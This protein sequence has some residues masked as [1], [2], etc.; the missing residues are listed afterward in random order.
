M[1]LFKNKIY[2]NFTF[3]QRNL[4]GL[5]YLLDHDFISPSIGNISLPVNAD[6]IYKYQNLL[7]LL[8]SFLLERW[9][10]TFLLFL[11]FDAESFFKMFW[12]Y[13]RYF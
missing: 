9:G 12:L 7:P 3:Y 11:Q 8:H 10:R 1:L 4:T 5:T 13:I 2:Y 6:W